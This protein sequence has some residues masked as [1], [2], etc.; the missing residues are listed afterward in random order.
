LSGA[1][2]ATVS[3]REMVAGLLNPET[4]VAATPR[5]RLLRFDAGHLSLDAG[6]EWASE[7]PGAR[8]RPLLATY[9]AAS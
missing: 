7:D 1:E 6:V 4:I 3:Q 5:L 2:T 8:A 9:E